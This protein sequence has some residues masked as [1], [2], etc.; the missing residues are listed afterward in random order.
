M[1]YNIDI[2]HANPALP[3]PGALKI[4][5]QSTCHNPLITGGIPPLG[6]T[7]A[8]SGG[9]ID[10]TLPIA[11]LV[12]GRMTPGWVKNTIKNVAA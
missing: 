7:A 12:D 9:I 5:V 1:K 10:A 3:F 6:I 2:V 11:L 8:T 4:H